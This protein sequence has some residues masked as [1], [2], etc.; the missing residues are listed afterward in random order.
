MS[1]NLTILLTNQSFST[2][3]QTY[4]KTSDLTIK[5]MV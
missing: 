3:L 5:I 2:T 4:K 1:C